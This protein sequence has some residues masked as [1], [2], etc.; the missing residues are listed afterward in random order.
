VE[1][2]KTLAA[3]FHEILNM[4]P[5]DQKLPDSIKQ[6]MRLF[7]QSKNWEIREIMIKNLS[8][9][10]KNFMKKEDLNC[11]VEEVKNYLDEIIKLGP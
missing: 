9:I 1:V 10:L 5:Q 11:I 4:F 8:L 2:L 3:G 7:F 6:S